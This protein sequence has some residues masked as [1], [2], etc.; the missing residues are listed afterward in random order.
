MRLVHWFSFKVGLPCT[1]GECSD[2]PQPLG[3]P[4]I[5]RIFAYGKSQYYEYLAMQRLGISLHAYFVSQKQPLTL[6]NL[7]SIAYQMVSSFLRSYLP[8]E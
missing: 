7:A 5:L 3:H 4:S 8:D 1:H 6:G 2:E